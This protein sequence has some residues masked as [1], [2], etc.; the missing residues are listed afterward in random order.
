MR[1]FTNSEEV[2]VLGAKLLRIVAFCEP[3]FGIMVVWEGIYYGTGRTRVVFIVESASMW[4][5]RILCT[6]LVIRAGY[7]VVEVWYCMIAD[8]IVKA[9]GLTIYGLRHSDVEAFHNAKQ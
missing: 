7:G 1:I 9:L 2:A 3:F 6:W 8:N 4:G 5:V